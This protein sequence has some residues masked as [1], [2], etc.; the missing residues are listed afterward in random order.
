MS[1]REVVERYFKH[2]QELRAGREGAVEALLDLWDED[3]V[4]EFAG[5]P[6]VVGTFKGRNAIHAL[7]KNRLA[8]NGM[9]IELEGDGGAEAARDAA[10]GLV[11]TRV[12]RVRSL[13]RKEPDDGAERIAAGW[14]TVIGTS[15]ERGF[16]ISGNHAF[17]IK[18]DLIQSLKV[19]AS[20]KADPTEQFRMEGLSVDD[21]GRLSLAAWAVV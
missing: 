12:H 11:E 16:E 1:A 15:D 13:D 2:I 8:A 6:P 19:V 3:G 10:L 17:L 21:I 14:T 18:D 5:A 20:P 7:Y 4:F 9:K